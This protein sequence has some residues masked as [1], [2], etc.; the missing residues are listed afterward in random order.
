MELAQ[1]GDGILGGNYQLYNVIITAHAF[2]MICAGCGYLLTLFTSRTIIRSI[3]SIIGSFL[4]GVDRDGTLKDWFTR[5]RESPGVRNN[6]TGKGHNDFPKPAIA[7]KQPYRDLLSL[8]GSLGFRYIPRTINANMRV[9][10]N[11][12]TNGTPNIVAAEGEPK[13]TTVTEKAS[14]GETRKTLDTQEDPTDNASADGMIHSELFESAVS[15]ESLKAAWVQLKSHPGM[16][17]PGVTKETLD[18]INE[19]W[20]FK[21]SELL[22]SGQYKYPHRRRIQIPKPGKTETRPLT[23]S[24]PRTKIIE[25]ALL[26]ALEPYFEGLWEWKKIDQEE[27][28]STSNVE[29]PGYTHKRN[30]E[31]YFKKFWINQ[32][33]FSKYSF[34]FRPGRSVHDA[35]RSVKLWSKNTVWFIDYDIRKAF[36]RVVRARLKNIFLTYIPEPRFW[37][38]IQKMIDAGILELDLTFEGRGVPR[39]SILSPFLF[40]IYLTKFD[41]FMDKLMKERNVGWKS[42]NDKLTANPVYKEYNNII[43]QFRSDHIQTTIARY[44]SIEAMKKALRDEKKAFFKKYGSQGGIDKL[45]RTI[46]YVRYADDFLVG[47][48]GPK[49][50]AASVRKDIN[51]FLKSDLHLE[52]KRDELIHRNKAGGVAFLGFNIY[53]VTPRKKTRV[54]WA[55]KEAAVR[56][57]RRLIAKL[58]D[59]DKK[60]AKATYNTIKKSLLAEF[61]KKAERDSIKPNESGIKLISKR[62]SSEVPKVYE[63]D[64]RALDPMTS[65]KL[66]KAEDYFRYLHKSNLD[67]ALL[68]YLKHTTN[69]EVEEVTGKDKQDI[70]RINN[71]KETFLEGINDI[72][73]ERDESVYA[74]R[75]RIL[76]EK[77]YQS[78]E[79]TRLRKAET[80]RYVK[81]SAWEN[82]SEDQTIEAADAITELFLEQEV[83]RKIAVYAP[84]EDIVG[85]L[86]TK[87]L[88]HPTKNRVCANQLMASLEDH[89]IVQCYRST[90]YGMLNFYSIADNFAKVKRLA[91]TLKLGCLYTLAR[92]HKKPGAWAI[93][94]YGPDAVITSG[95]DEELASLPSDHKIDNLPVSRK[96]APLRPQ[97]VGF[98]IENIVRKFTQ[99]LTA[100]SA[101]FKK[102]AVQDCVGGKIE[103]HHVRKL[104][105]RITAE[106]KISVKTK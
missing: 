48:V 37:L 32:P 25:R 70:E 92:K 95:N 73:R 94:I 76:L 2:L 96:Y 4:T 78:L 98:D 69:L 41:E 50:F 100:G 43:R 84:M 102:C 58:G 1:P 104:E 28:E 74:E 3:R 21:A 85:K 44:G 8:C 99:R 47:I 16:I 20:F 59:S 54:K 10:F 40:N 14:V 89:V 81:P 56:Y 17:K 18:G 13:A 75:R 88:M 30:K 101:L 63:P 72:I 9:R 106:G 105:R 79:R 51:N 71:L 46:L 49:E 55:H 83:V 29:C 67:S 11:T 27:Y 31:G 35:I 38:E 62:L 93:S 90:I 5:P 15:P 86:R 82:I 91:K 12:T 19:D 22:K 36:D 39:G 52:V 66:R 57:K 7:A 34:G 64:Q 23:I 77:R 80:H 97:Q 53:L 60:L 24:N 87:G 26:N 61:R 42:K 33:I 103:I 65:Y 45:T 6:I 68:G